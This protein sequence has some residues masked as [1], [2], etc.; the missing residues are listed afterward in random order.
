MNTIYQYFFLISRR[1]KSIL[2]YPLD[3]TIGIVGTV[4]W[5]IPG[6]IMIFLLNQNTNHLQYKVEYL[7]VLYGL[8]VFGD[9]IQHTLFEALWQ[10]GNKFI[11]GGDFDNVLTKPVPRFIQVITSRFDVDGI[12]GVLLGLFC[13]IYGLIKM[14]LGYFP[15]V[16]FI[17]ALICSASV[18]IGINTITAATAFLIYNNFPLT[19]S[20]FQFHMF[21]RYPKTAYPQWISFT[22]SFLFPVFWATYYPAK[23]FLESNILNLFYIMMLCVVFLFFSII[24]WI[25]LS[26]K[27]KS[28]GT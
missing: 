2:Q 24:I 23:Q 20:I 1:I 4:L 25:A 15:Y 17:M 19:N 13:C 3:V 12:G 9:G 5:H 26:K 22:L 11:I 28:S 10:F 7:I 27:Y 6:L 16:Q 18:Y 8:S 14:N 21:A